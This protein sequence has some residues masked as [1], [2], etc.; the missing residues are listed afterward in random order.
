MSAKTLA[1]R[2]AFGKELIEVA[3]TRDDFVVC[4]ADT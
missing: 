2:M 4:S 1:T 3:K